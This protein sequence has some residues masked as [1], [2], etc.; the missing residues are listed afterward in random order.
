MKRTIILGICILILIVLTTTVSAGFYSPILKGFE[1][2][3]YTFTE[4][5]EIIYPTI[6]RIN[7]SPND[8]DVNI[9]DINET[10]LIINYNITSDSAINNSTVELTYFLDTGTDDCWYYINGTC[11][12]SP[13]TTNQTSS[14]NEVYTFNLDIDYVYPHTT[15]FNHEYFEDIPHALYNF[16]GNSEWVK[17]TFLNISN[18]TSFGYLEFM[19]NSSNTGSIEIFVCNSSYSTGSPK[20]NDNCGLVGSAP[21]T[22]GYDHKHS[23]YSMHNV[24]EFSINNSQIA[25]V[26]ITNEMQFLG[27]SKTGDW[28]AYYITN[29][30]RLGYHQVSTNGGTTWT[31]LNSG[32]GTWDAHI[33]QFRPTDTLKYNVT[34]CDIDGHCNTSVTSEDLLQLGNQSPSTPQV[35][36]PTDGT[37]EGVIN[38]NWTESISPNGYEIINY[39]VSL[40]YENETYIQH[41]INTTNLYTTFNISNVS[42]GQYLIGVYATDEIGQVSG[43]YF[44]GIIS[45]QQVPLIQIDYPVD[46]VTYNVSISNLNYTIIGNSEDKCWYSL[47]GGTTNST[48]ITGGTNFTSV[49]FT[50]GS[51][52]PIVY[53]NNTIG[54]VGS[55]SVTFTIS[56]GLR[57]TYLSYKN[58]R[59][60]DPLIDTPDGYA[61]IYCYRFKGGHESCFNGTDW[62]YD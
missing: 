34:A 23:N 29:S 9:F 39:T 33:H 49:P 25:G 17:V 42:E 26:G 43:T 44:S 19:A 1:L 54:R 10:R 36:Y 8:L 14:L 55:D 35:F 13:K 40:Y 62:V 24:F 57:K 4:T 18:E 60:E 30:S 15:F 45:N 20:T 28:D 38:I 7:Q 59:W 41:I 21:A 61:D 46:G 53:C 5:G 12:N 58:I 11:F 50:E 32:L 47:D 48:P 2:E 56:L 51:N 22:T 31:N 37:Y 52:T 6:V 27:N 3:T 16:A